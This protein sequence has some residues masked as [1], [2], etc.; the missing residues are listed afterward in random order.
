LGGCGSGAEQSRVDASGYI[1]RGRAMFMQI[2]DAG[3]DGA[4]VSRLG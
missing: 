2:C 4:E 3:K 1:S